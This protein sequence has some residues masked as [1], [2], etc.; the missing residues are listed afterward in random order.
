MET[1]FLT[2]KRRDDHFA[3][4]GDLG[5]EEPGGALKKQIEMRREIKQVKKCMYTYEIFYFQ[6]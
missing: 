3:E 1:A 5:Q 4:K 2:A 6:F